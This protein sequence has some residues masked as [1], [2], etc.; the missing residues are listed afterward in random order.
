[1]ARKILDLEALYR[2]VYLDGDEEAIRDLAFGLLKVVRLRA[3]GPQRGA[4]T[5]PDSE[6][7]EMACRML[8]RCQSNG[9]PPP[10][11]LAELIRTQLRRDRPLSINRG[12]F[13]RKQIMLAFRKD[14]PKAS[15]RQIAK[16][17]HVHHT[18]V[19]RWLRV[20]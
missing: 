1:M 15:L 11:H 7:N 16:A 19:R 13:L 12:Y 14:N 2:K 4:N 17:V 3:G 10:Q 18:T 20:V 6:V 5:I 9:I 8:D